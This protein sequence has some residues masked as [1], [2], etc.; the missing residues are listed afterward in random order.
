MKKV[1][2]RIC[3]TATLITNWFCTL[4]GI[5]MI[6]FTFAHSYDKEKESLIVPIEVLDGMQ[7]WEK[8]VRKNNYSKL[9][10]IGSEMCETRRFFK[11]M[12][13]QTNYS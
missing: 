7:K 1:P 6:E 10:I 11:A 8:Y 5:E 4:D 9:D 13:R 12:L 2:Q 3:H